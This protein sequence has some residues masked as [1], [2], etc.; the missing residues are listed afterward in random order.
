MG[1]YIVELDCMF[2]NC[3][4][5]VVL[6]FVSPSFPRARP[7]PL[8]YSVTRSGKLLHFKGSAFH[9]VIPGTFG[10]LFLSN[11]QP[12]VHILIVERPLVSRI[13][14]AGRRFYEG[15][16]NVRASLAFLLL[17]RL[18]RFFCCWKEGASFCSSVSLY[19]C[20][21]AEVESQFMDKNSRMVCFGVESLSLMAPVPTPLLTS[22][23]RSGYDFDFYFFSIDAYMHG[24]RHFVLCNNDGNSQRRM[25]QKISN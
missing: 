13:Y 22:S 10:I 12:H 6:S 15:E 8:S 4:L 20:H 23:D 21:Y 18:V 19:F 17:G 25:L 24:L 7:L 3:S 16:W 9:R 11:H 5:R 1:R 2:Y 14:G